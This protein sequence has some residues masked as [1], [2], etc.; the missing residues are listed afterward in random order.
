MAPVPLRGRRNEP[1]FVVHTL[2]KIAD[3]RGMEPEALAEITTQN[4]LRA[5]RIESEESR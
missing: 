2:N 3:I 4:A 1:A 5:F